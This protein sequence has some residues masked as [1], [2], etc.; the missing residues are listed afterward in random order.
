MA[1]GG[2]SGG[3]GKEHKP[4]IPADVSIPEMTLKAVVLGIILSITSAV[5]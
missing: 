3:G 4:Y 1:E 2:G 5:L